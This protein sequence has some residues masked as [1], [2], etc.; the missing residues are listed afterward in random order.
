VHG[1][2]RQLRRYIALCESL[3]GK[4][5]QLPSRVIYRGEFAVCEWRPNELRGAARLGQ[6]QA[7][8]HSQGSRDRGGGEQHHCG[9]ELPFVRPPDVMQPRFFCTLPAVGR[10]CGVA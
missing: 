8:N 5:S 10:V 9:L 7:E 1:K 6:P 4:P 3:P 2:R